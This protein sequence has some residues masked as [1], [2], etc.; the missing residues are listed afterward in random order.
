M[1]NHKNCNCSGEC[2]EA[3]VEHMILPDGRRA[4]RHVSYDADGNEVVEVFAEEKR[5]VKLEK[6][7][8]RKHKDIVAEE[9]TEMVKDGEIAHREVRSLEPQN[10]L[11]IVERI[12][13]AN[14]SKVVDGDYVRKDEVGKIVSDA[15]VEGVSALM[16]SMNQPIMENNSHEPLFNAQSQVE[17]NVEEKKKKS[18]SLVYFLVGCV[19]IEIVALAGYM[20]FIG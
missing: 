7:I 15:V 20:Y 12:G 9:I 6:R 10:P 18:N 19:V 1:S 5:P 4:E 13:V 14:H 11:Q 8:T 3:V 16:E 2:N 17:M